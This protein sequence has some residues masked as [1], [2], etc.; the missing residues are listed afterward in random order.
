MKQNVKQAL[1]N[2]DI[3]YDEVID[4]ATDIFKTFLSDIDNIIEVAYNNIENMS[5][6][7]IRDNMLRLSLSSYSFSEIKEKATFKAVLGE[8]LRKES[9]SR[10]F[11]CT[12]GTVAVRENTA[13]INTSAEILAE[14][15]YTLV[16]SM[17]KTKLDEMHRVVDSLKTVLMSRM[18]EAKL[19]SVDTQ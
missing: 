9:Y 14:E 6:D 1:D 11:N 5:N 7:A 8:T 10:N 2:I 15:I 19:S 13:I 3:T 16:S 4:V 12:D 18:Q 17:F